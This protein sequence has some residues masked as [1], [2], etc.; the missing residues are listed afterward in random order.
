MQQ[1]LL[2][3]SDLLRSGPDLRRSGCADLRRSSR[4]V[5]QLV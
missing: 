5:L 4:R 1:V 3:R 2:G